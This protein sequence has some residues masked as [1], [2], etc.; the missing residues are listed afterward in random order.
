MSDLDDLKRKHPK[1]S[2]ESKQAHE[3]RLELIGSG[4]D[5]FSAITDAVQDLSREI[6]EAQKPKDNHIFAYKGVVI[7]YR[8]NPKTLG[9]GI[10]QSL[11]SLLGA[12]E[13]YHETEPS[14]PGKNALERKL[15][16][17]IDADP[18]IPFE[19]YADDLGIV[20]LK[21]HRK[22]GGS[23]GIIIGSE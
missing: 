13:T 19:D 7:T 17:L 16:K 10:E 20:I 4:K 8:L 6:P 12:F 2:F 5:L 3:D 18:D 1:K 22:R 15:A 11:T 23:S 21:V 9:D 14:R